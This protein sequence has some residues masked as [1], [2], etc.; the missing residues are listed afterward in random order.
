MCLLPCEM[1]AAI[2]TLSTQT[3]LH[4]ASTVIKTILFCSKDRL[5]WSHTYSTHALYV[6]F[7]LF[8]MQ[9]YTETDAQLG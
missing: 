4:Q 6:G 7:V 8:L 9:R 3:P 1:T 2:T 5:Q